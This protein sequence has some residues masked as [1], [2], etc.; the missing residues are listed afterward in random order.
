MRDLP[1]IPLVAMSAGPGV[2]CSPRVRNLRMLDH[3]GRADL[4]SIWLDG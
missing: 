2:R 3:L 1:V 4:T